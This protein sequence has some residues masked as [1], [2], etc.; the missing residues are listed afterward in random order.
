MKKMLAVSRLSQAA[1]ECT[2]SRKRPLESAWQFI[3]VDPPEVSVIRIR[4]VVLDP[5]SSW[6]AGFNK[7]PLDLDSKMGN[8]L[9]HELAITTYTWR[10]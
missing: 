9:L 1:L 5:A 7:A 10:T 6:R 4:D 8:L 2:G 3:E